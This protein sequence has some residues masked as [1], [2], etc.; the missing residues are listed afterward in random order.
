LMAFVLDCSM[1]MA[2]VF[3]DE[4]SEFTDSLRESLLKDHAVV[5]AIWRIE[6]GNV[7]L[8]ATRRGRISSDDW[9]R[10]RDNLEALPIDVDPE[11]CGRVLESVLPIAYERKLSV[12][13]AMYLEIA[14]RRGLPLATLDKELGAAGKKARV[15]VL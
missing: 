5:P 11:S 4:A 3:P 8:V 13:D 15:E 1:T 12:Y 6:V 9:P 7:L 10:I 2:W 14:L